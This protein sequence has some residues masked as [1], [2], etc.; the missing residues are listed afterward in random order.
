MRLNPS[1][2]TN[3]LVRDAEWPRGWLEFVC[4]SSSHLDRKGDPIHVGPTL[5]WVPVRRTRRVPMKF[6]LICWGGGGSDVVI[7]VDS[8]FP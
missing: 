4:V 5:T 8:C 3:C 1:L 7:Y 2:H 6:G